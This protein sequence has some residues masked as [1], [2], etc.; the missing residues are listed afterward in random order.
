MGGGKVMVDTASTEL[1]PDVGNI[2]GSGAEAVG[3]EVG[4]DVG[5]VEGIV[6]ETMVSEVEKVTCVVVAGV[7]IAV[8]TVDTR[9]D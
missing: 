4:P 8:R 7:L 1:G 3:T 5:N 6:E 9:G 2:E